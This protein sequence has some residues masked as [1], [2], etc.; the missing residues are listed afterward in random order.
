MLSKE[1]WHQADTGY[2][3]SRLLCPC[4]HQPCCR[5]RGSRDPGG[6]RRVRSPLT[7][8]WDRPWATPGGGGG[9]P[10]PGSSWTDPPPVPRGLRV[11][12]A[13]ASKCLPHGVPG[14]PPSHQG[15]PCL[16]EGQPRHPVEL[17]GPQ[18]PKWPR[19][20]QSPHT[21][22]L[23]FQTFGDFQSPF[24]L[25]ARLPPGFLQPS[26][27]SGASLIPGN[28]NIIVCGPT[29][30]GQSRV[31]ISPPLPWA[32]R[33]HWCRVALC[34]TRVPCTP[35]DPVTRS[36]QTL[37]LFQVPGP[38]EPWGWHIVGIPSAC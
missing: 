5:S 13:Q 11:Q 28:P 36:F 32:G 34:I 18:T 1:A 30:P 3:D 35:N 15:S 12:G 27:P 33:A 29:L 21:S 7:C 25:A 23:I 20:T 38:P 6:Q 2:P 9:A 14:S 24:G 16:R 37:A 26:R 31:Q 22:G 8:P 10:G 19:G 4:L 17:A